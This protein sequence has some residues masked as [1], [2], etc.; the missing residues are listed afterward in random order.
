MTNAIRHNEN[1]GFV[2]IYMV[3]YRNHVSDA[4]SFQYITTDY[5]KIL[6]MVEKIKG[7]LERDEDFIISSI[8]LDNEDLVTFTKEFFHNIM[9]D[10]VKAD[11]RV[12]VDPYV[13]LK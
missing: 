13:V 7:E 12:T 9:D 8:I 2:T 1:E 4:M 5:D 6:G 10:V 3:G 11:A